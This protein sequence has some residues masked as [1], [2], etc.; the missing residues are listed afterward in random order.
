MTICMRVFNRIEC[1]T[2]GYPA[3]EAKYSLEEASYDPGCRYERE[4]YAA[5]D[6][7]IVEIEEGAEDLSEFEA[8]YDDMYDEMLHSSYFGG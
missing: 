2:C 1:P 3:S 7:G 4:D 6:P 5:P 8:M